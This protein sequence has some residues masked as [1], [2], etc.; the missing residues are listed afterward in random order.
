MSVF[1]AFVACL[2]LAL[3]G[4]QSLAVNLVANGGFET[5]D[6]TGWSTQAAPAGSLFGVVGGGYEGVYRARFGAAGFLDEIYQN[7]PTAAGSKFTISFW[8]YN[9]DFGQ[10]NFQVLWN[11]AL[12][13][14]SQPVSFPVD[15]WTEVSLTAYATSAFSELR[16]AAYDVPAYVYIDDVRV[17]PDNLIVNPSFE[18]GF[19]GWN[20]QPAAFGSS[21][22]VHNFG[23][24]TGAKYSYFAATGGLPD[25]IWQDVPTSTG[26]VY[27]LQFW[28]ANFPREDSLRVFWEGGLIFDGTPL[29]A[30]YPGWS[31]LT[32]MVTSTATTSELRFEAFDTPSSIALDDVYLAP[33]ANPACLQ[34][35]DADHSGTVE[36]GDI[37]AVLRSWGATCLP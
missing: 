36:F 5:G 19:A 32:F 12:I 20:T 17:E 34:D 14:F 23:G 6:F 35:G 15:T 27:V 22:K 29:P 33:A 31:P 11:G 25:L 9:A 18:E 10:D 37:T 4:T 24:H 1:R 21:F 16:F 7:I 8:V 3:V 13:H 28:F 30:A 26:R 2:A